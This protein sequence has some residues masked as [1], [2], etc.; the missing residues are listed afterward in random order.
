MKELFKHEINKK[1]VLDFAC[2][3]GILSILSEK[4]GAQMINSID[5]CSNACINAKSNLSENK[6]YKSKL[7]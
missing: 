5:I 6:C 7:L 4:L 1:S 2:G 3:T